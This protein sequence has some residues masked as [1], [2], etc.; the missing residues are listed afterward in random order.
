MFADGT[1]L[2]GAV[3]S[4]REVRRRADEGS[5]SD[6]EREADEWHGERAEAGKMLELW[7]ASFRRR[8]LRW[9]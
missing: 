2:S 5:W 8:P 4:L 9:L 1:D 6:G 7:E 3:A